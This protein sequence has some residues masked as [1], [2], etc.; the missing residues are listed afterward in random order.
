MRI[1]LNVVPFA[2]EHAIDII[3]RNRVNGK[4]LS[5]K[6][7][8]EMLTAYLSP[9]SA[10]FTLMC[11]NAPV[12][13]AG[14]INLG[15]RR[16]EAWILISSL[17]YKYKLTAVRELKKR[18]PEVATENGFC[19]VQAVS[20]IEEYGRWFEILGFEREGILRHYGPS[21]ETVIMY[22]RIFNKDTVKWN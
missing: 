19:R 6:M 22:S 12:A 3:T 21:G 11:F 14:I 18:L 5:E 15:W 4:V 1:E 9:G 10:A 7:V 20:V 17:F 8:N 2:A 13:S 16:G